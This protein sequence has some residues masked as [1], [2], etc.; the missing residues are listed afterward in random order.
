MAG[1]RTL[2]IW[3]NH[4]KYTSNC[5]KYTKQLQQYDQ[6]GQERD[7]YLSTILHLQSDRFSANSRVS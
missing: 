3:K 6:K 2:A 1:E 5:L 7:N 4:T